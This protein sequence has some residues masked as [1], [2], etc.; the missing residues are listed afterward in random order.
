MNKPILMSDTA[1]ARTRWA[2][3][4]QQAI[5]VL[6]ATYGADAEAA[7]AEIKALGGTPPM[8]ARVPGIST[9]ATRNLTTRTRALVLHYRPLI[10]ADR[11]AHAET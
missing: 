10:E 3:R 5:V 6:Q 9:T 4:K 7:V 11:H 2:G 1:E 8:R